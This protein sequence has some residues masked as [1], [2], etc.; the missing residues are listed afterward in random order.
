MVDLSFGPV[1]D[2]PRLLRD[3]EPRSTALH[4]VDEPLKTT[5]EEILQKR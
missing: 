3:L 5:K 1:K 4:I 2:D